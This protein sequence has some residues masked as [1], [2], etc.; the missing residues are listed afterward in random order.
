MI[1][2][3]IVMWENKS[4]IT[5]SSDFSKEARNMELDVKSIHF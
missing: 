4:Y 2:V 5:K 1:Q 3:I